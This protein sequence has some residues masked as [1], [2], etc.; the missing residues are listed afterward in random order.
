[1]QNE[2][3]I[4]GRKEKKRKKKPVSVL[5]FSLSLRSKTKRLNQT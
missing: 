4:E 3:F 5:F 1:M 2:A